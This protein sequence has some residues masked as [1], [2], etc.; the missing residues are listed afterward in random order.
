M[1][2]LRELFL[3]TVGLEVLPGQLSLE[4]VDEHVD[5][6]LEVVSAA[7]LDSHVGVDAGVPHRPPGMLPVPEFEVFPGAGH[8]LCGVSE[9]NHEEQV[10]FV[11]QADSEVGG[12]HVP[13][14][15]P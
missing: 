14:Y 7:A 3:D 11:P 12:L 8:V 15:E 4:E 10:R 1:Q 5:Q 9:V 2:D 6:R 13:V